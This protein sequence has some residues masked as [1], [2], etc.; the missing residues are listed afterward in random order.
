MQQIINFLIKSR[1]TLWFLFLLLIALIFTIQSHTYHSNK[2][3]NSTGFLVGGIYE[4]QN[5]IVEYFRLKK[6][7]QRLLEENTKLKENIQKLSR[8]NFDPNEIVLK[9]TLKE[10]KYTY[11]YAQVINSTYRKKKNYLTLNKGKV[12]GITADMGVITDLGIVGIVDQVSEKYATVI[13]IINENS[14]INAQLKK[15]NHFGSLIWNGENPNVVQLVDIPRLAP[16][17]KGDTIITGGRSTIFPK[18]IPIGV[19]KNFS[20]NNDQNYFTVNVKLFNDMTDVGFVQVVTNN[21]ALEIKHIE[22][23]LNE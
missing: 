1:N 7:N 5:N 2:F 6:Y 9:D 19:I 12:N 8:V 16:L 18:G 17:V 15:S 20:L 21:E 22:N 23:T 14:R 11:N 10:T 3:I 4:F 13:S